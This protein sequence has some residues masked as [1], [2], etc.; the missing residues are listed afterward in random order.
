MMEQLKNLANAYVNN[1][2]SVVLHFYFFV[3]YLKMNNEGILL[4][5][6]RQQLQ[7]ALSRSRNNQF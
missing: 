4:S 1:Q 6:I 3:S 2:K 7:P 5:G